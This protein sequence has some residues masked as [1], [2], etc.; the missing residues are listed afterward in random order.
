MWAGRLRLRGTD[1][2]AAPTASWVRRAE[3]LA[4]PSKTLVSA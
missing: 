3:P 2:P 4:M 1:I